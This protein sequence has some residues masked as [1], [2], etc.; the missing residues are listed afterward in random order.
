MADKLLVHLGV[1]GVG[2]EGTRVLVAGIEACNLLAQLLKV[3][4]L[5][6]IAGATLDGLFA[7]E[8]H[9]LQILGEAAGRLTHHALE[10]ADDGVGECKRFAALNDILGG[11]VVLHHEYRKV[12][13]HLR[14]RRYLDDIAE[15]EVDG[16]VHFLD[17]AEA[18]AK[19]DRFDLRLQVRVLAAG[20]LVAVDIGDGNLEP[21][22]ELLIA[23]ADIAPVIAQLL[24]ALRVEARVA[25]LTA[26]SLVEGVHARLA[27]EVCHGADGGVDNVAAGFRCKQQ[28]CKLVAGGVVRMQVYRQADLLLEGGD[29]LLSRIG[30]EKAGHI[31]N[32]QDMSAALFKL[33]CEIDIVL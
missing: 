4:R 13:D 28:R 11:Q 16:A 33:L 3:D 18:V 23:Q 9:S 19:A 30:L 2:N 25:L 32:G 29:E 6:K 7:L 5:E 26:Q 21:L 24:Q 12:A 8:D 17:L 1:H 15:H 10:V 14:R 20:Y 27:R 31:L 22:V